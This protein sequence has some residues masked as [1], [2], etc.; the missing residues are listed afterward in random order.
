M[1]R[2]DPVYLRRLET[3]KRILDQR[4]SSLTAGVMAKGDQHPPSRRPVAVASRLEN[5]SLSDVLHEASGL[6]YFM[7]FMD[8]QLLMTVVQFWIVVNGFRNPLED[9]V[10]ED[11][12]SP[13]APPTWTDSDRTDLAQINQAYLSKPE[14]HVTDAAREAVRAFLAAGRG[15]TP[16]QYQ[17]ARQAILRT[18]NST[19]HE[20]E[21]RQFPKFKESDLFY[22]YLTSDEAASN[23]IPDSP[24]PQRKPLA[25]ATTQIPALR[26][27]PLPAVPLRLKTAGTAIRR[28]AAS[29]GDLK[30]SSKAT[31]DTGSPRR[32]LDSDGPTSLS[33]D[34][35]TD[36]PLSHSRQ[37]IDSEPTSVDGHD[38]PDKQVVEVMEA[39]LNDIMEQAPDAD[40]TRSPLFGNEALSVHSGHATGMS[41]SSSE[42][43]RNDSSSHKDPEKPSI[44][45]LGLVNTSSRIGVFSD[46]DRFPDEEKFLQ[47]EHDDPEEEEQEGKVDEEIHEAAPGDLGLAE[48]ISALT[49]DIERLV[50]QDSVVDSL[51]M[52][53]ELTNNT[54]ELR[55]LRKSKA[56]LQREIRR[57]GLQRQQYV[58][59]ESDNSLYGRSTVRI[60]SIV[61]GTEEDGREYASCKTAL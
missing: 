18:Q 20:M 37:S 1:A 5:A 3:A 31:T 11:D 50:A 21:S 60:K 56:S 41:R 6:S 46:D 2:Q 16:Q 45:S 15:A 29:S 8:R 42:F 32:S 23:R 47:D 4:V 61:S 36:D 34:N 10:A 19:F 53:A 25:R 59:Q 24:T 44:A 28:A 58:V 38:G 54:A 35:D 57:K 52:K 48:A 30:A 7:E 12:P 51:T 9:A 33:D 39:A 26:P 17:N 49:A 40:D 22:K 13:A 27:Q 43:L 55:I 14:L